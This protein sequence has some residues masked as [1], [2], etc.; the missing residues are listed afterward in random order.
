MYLLNVIPSGPPGCSVG[1]LSEDMLDIVRAQILARTVVDQRSTTCVTTR[2]NCYNIVKLYIHV[3]SWPIQLQLNVTYWNGTSAL[4]LV[5]EGTWWGLWIEF[6][7]EWPL[8]STAFVFQLKRTVNGRVVDFISHD[9]P[10][11]DI[12]SRGKTYR[13]KPRRVNS[14]M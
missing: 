11:I 6:T 3:I 9:C 14:I 1:L 10:F 12:E 13:K 2:S 4:S 8:P 7:P 5:M